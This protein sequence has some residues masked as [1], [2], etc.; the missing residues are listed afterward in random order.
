ML[1]TEGWDERPFA[2]YTLLSKGDLSNRSLVQAPP[3][4]PTWLA[5]NNDSDYDNVVMMV[6]MV[7]KT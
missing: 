6:V 3:T 7:I 4:S 5:R 1:I 2:Q